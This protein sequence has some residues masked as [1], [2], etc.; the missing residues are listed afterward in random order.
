MIRP[1]G[2]LYSI[3][4]NFHVS[5]EDIQKCNGLLDTGLKAFHPLRVPNPDNV[6][7]N[8]DMLVELNESV[9]MAENSYTVRKG[10][11][12]TSIAEKFNVPEELII[13]MN[14]LEGVELKEGQKLKLYIRGN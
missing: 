12:V 11:T 2:T 8:L 4:R 7:P 1:K 3:S 13:E 9:V 5:I 14:A 6:R 10:E